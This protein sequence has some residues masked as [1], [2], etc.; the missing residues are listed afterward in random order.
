MRG[1]LRRNFDTLLDN[2]VV[3]SYT[4]LGYAL[5]QVAWKD[6]NLD[7]GMTGQGWMWRICKRRQDI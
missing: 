6:A 4:W 3:L 5:R 2:R 7:V 1:M